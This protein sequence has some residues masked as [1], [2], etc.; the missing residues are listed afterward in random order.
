MKKQLNWKNII[1]SITYF[2]GFILSLFFVEWSTMSLGEYLFILLFVSCANISVMTGWH[3]YFTHR[4]FKASKWV[5]YFFLFFGSSIFTGSVLEWMSEHLNHHKFENDEI[6]DPTCI[7][8]GFF[9]AHMGWIFYDQEIPLLK[10][11]RKIVNWHHKNWLFLS[12]LSGIV[13]PFILYYLLFGSL[14]N[15]LLIG[16]FFRTFISQQM[17]FLVGSWAH[18]F[19]EKDNEGKTSATNSLFVSICCFGE[20]YHLN[21]HKN[22]IDYRAGYKWYDYDP[23]KWFVFILEKLNLAWDLKRNENK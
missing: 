12:F 23:G 17:L 5:D 21:H 4:S 18:V 16:I 8:K 13:I 2:I 6:K 7:K 11:N 10:D 14:L 22:P 15:A 20:G 9:Y 3:R 19:G 1:F